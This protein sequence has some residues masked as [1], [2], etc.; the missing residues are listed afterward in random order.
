MRKNIPAI[1]FA[2]AIIIAAYLAMQSLIRNRP[3]GHY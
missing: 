1:L 2:L 3:Q